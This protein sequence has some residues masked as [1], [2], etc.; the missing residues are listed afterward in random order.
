MP[1]AFD[2]GAAASARKL[3]RDAVVQ[4]LAALLK[5]NGLYMMAVQP[6]PIP[7]RDEAVLRHMLTSH[8]NGR[9]PAAT[10]AL[11]DGSFESA[12]AG[13]ADEWVEDVEVEIGLVSSHARGTLARMEGDTASLASLALDPGIET[14]SEHVRER[15]AG[16]T[17][18]AAGLKAKEL[19]PEDQ[20]PIYFAQ[21]FTVWRQRYSVQIRADVNRLRGFTQLLEGIDADH[22]EQDATLSTETDIP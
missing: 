15:L 20:G 16:W 19:R 3:L 4:R 9:S 1:H 5:E 17:P 10:V 18:T 21:D 11:G 13:Y 7:F 6:L 22:V 14:M 12:G 8:V 2:T